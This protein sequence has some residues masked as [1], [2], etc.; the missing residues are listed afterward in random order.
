MYNA[1]AI[2]A[3]LSDKH[4]YP[5]RPIDLNGEDEDAADTDSKLFEAY[6]IR[7]NREMQNHHP[8]T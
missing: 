1:H 5:Q 7:F 8:N 3:C 4:S 2:S 6:A